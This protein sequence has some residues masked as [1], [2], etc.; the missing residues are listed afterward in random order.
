MLA[1]FCLLIV[2]FFVL[3][4]LY[5]QKNFSGMA[6]VDQDSST[7]SPPLVA[8]SQVEVV[9]LLSLLFFF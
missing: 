5:E 9:N 8:S 3:V 1:A 4:F 2:F 7:E 6:G